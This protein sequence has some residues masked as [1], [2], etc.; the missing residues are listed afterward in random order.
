M[1]RE[2]F[3]LHVE[4]V[5]ILGV[6][7]SEDIEKLAKFVSEVDP[8]IPSSDEFREPSKQDLTDAVQER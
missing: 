1:E 8:S 3:M 4:T 7:D 5:L 6:N 2:R